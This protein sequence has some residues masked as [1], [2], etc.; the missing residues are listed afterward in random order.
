MSTLFMPFISFLH[1]RQHDIVTEQQQFRITVL[2]MAVI[3]IFLICH[4]PT[5]VYLLYKLWHEK[6][7]EQGHQK[8][9][10]S[11]SGMFI[12]R[13]FWRLYQFKMFRR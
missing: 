2:L 10:N 11:I 7:Q 12:G 3:V 13:H 6:E 8:T 1:L 9:E 4:T 5:A